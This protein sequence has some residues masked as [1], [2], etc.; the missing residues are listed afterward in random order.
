MKTRSFGGWASRLRIPRESQSPGHAE[1]IA[2]E[3]VEHT[4]AEPVGRIKDLV[5]KPTHLAL[6][7]HEF[8]AHSTELDRIAGYEANYAGTSFVKIPDIGKLKYGSPALQRQCRPH[9]PD[10]HGTVGSTMTA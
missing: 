3:A 1:R 9:L 7:I 4:M 8:V 5:L 6:T 10:G 2:A